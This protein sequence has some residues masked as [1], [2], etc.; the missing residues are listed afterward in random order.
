[1]KT[2]RI[3]KLSEC[4]LV[5]YNCH[6]A[7]EDVDKHGEEICEQGYADLKFEGINWK[8]AK[9]VWRR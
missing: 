3:H 8:L 6:I 2:S 4:F 1:M 5:W 9:K 7:E